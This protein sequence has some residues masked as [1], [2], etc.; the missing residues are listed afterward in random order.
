MI[1]QF[2]ACECLIN[3]SEQELCIT[4]YI[5]IYIQVYDEQQSLSIGF[6]QPQNI[7]Q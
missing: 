6:C 4:Y 7:Q 1:R 3:E 2:N 5:Y